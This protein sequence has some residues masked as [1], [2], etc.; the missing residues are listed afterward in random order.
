MND[1]VLV[2]ARLLNGVLAGIYLA[3]LVAVMPALH[4]QPDDVYARVMN[5]VNVVIVNPVFMAFFLGAPA[6]AVVLLHWHRTPASFT[7]A[8]LAVAALLITAVANVPLNNALAKGGAVSS[9]ETPWLIWHVVRTLMATAAFV[10]L[11]LAPVRASQ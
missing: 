4:G 6:L 11:N 2:L 1:L 3:F 7:A 9:F 10:L 5:R 8:G